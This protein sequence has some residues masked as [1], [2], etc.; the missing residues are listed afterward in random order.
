MDANETMNRASETARQFQDQAKN[1]ISDFSNRMRAR[2]KAAVNSTDACVREYTWSS[3][4]LAA[5]LGVV[6]GLM[7]RRA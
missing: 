3:I 2:S 1:A 5:V 7:I 4:A 6:V